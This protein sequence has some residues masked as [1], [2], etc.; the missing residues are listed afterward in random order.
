MQNNI[1]P[2]IALS[3][4]NVP[5]VFGT[6]RLL[7]NDK[8]AANKSKIGAYLAI[9]IITAV[10]IFQYPVLFANPPK[11]EPLLALALVNSYKT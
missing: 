7:A 6:F 9:S 2:N 4:L 11:S 3:V 1:T 5:T 8:P 10:S